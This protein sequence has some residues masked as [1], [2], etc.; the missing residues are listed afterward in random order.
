MFYAD[1]TVFLWSSDASGFVAVGIMDEVIDSP[2]ASA[3]DVSCTVFCESLQL[4][5]L[6][7][8]SSW[9]ESILHSVKSVS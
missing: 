5:L 4:L 6:L 9:A 3:M 7:R 8:S 2:S 1:K